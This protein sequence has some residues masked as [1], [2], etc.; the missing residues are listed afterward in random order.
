VAP[1]YDPD[2]G[3]LFVADLQGQLYRFSLTGERKWVYN[4][5]EAVMSLPRAAA[6]KLADAIYNHFTTNQDPFLPLPPEG[7]P[8]TDDEWKARLVE[9]GVA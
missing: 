6:L 1:L 3:D 8:A 5:A 9:G 2:S 7:V 4:G